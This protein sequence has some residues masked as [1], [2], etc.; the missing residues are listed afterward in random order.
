MILITSAQA[1]QTGDNADP[2]GC[3][4]APSYPNLVAAG[5]QPAPTTTPTRP[6]NVDLLDL[7]HRSRG[8]TRREAEPTKYTEESVL[9]TGGGGKVGL[10]M[11]SPYVEAGKVEETEYANHF[12]LLKSLEKMFGVEP[13]GYATEETMPTLS[14]SLFRSAEEVEAEAAKKAEGKG[15]GEEVE[16][17]GHEQGPPSLERLQ[18]AAEITRRIARTSSATPR[19]FLIVGPVKRRERRAPSWA[20]GSTPTE[21]ASARRSPW[22]TVSVPPIRCVALAVP[23]IQ[24]RTKCEVAVAMWVGKPSAPAISGT[25]M[26]PPPIPRKLERKPTPA[27]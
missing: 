13:L 25:W 15:R 23:D 26:T 22:P 10:L 18:P 2:S 20:P 11:I 9:E 17:Q 6:R 14:P 19:N 5:I 3:C 27:L 16:G 21:S 8:R 1:P 7:D 4:L 12:T 24:T